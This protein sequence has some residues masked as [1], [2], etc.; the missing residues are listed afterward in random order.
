M[1]QHWVCLQLRFNPQKDFNL[2]LA[3]RRAALSGNASLIATF[4]SHDL[5]H[6]RVGQYPD[7]HRDIPTVDPPVIMT[8]ES[9]ILAGAII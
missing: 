7:R 1:K 8:M 4:S 2:A 9:Y 6:Q 3:S 5:C